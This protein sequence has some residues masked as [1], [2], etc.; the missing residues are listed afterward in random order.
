MAHLE[1]FV[2]TLLYYLV[3]YLHNFISYM[4][5]RMHVCFFNSCQWPFE[6]RNIPKV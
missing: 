2:S 6:S 5:L 1:S 4:H 3:F